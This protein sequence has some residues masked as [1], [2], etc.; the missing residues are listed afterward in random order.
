MALFKVGGRLRHRAAARGSAASAIASPQIVGS[1]DVLDDGRIV[2]WA[3]D[4]AVPERRVLLEAV[5]GDSR[6]RAIADRDRP[7]LRAAGQGDGCHGFEIRFDLRGAGCAPVHLREVV[8]GQALPGS[9]LRYDPVHLLADPVHRGR[10]ELLRAEAEHARLALDLDAPSVEDT[11]AQPGYATRARIETL[12]APAEPLHDPEGLITCYLAHRAEVARRPIS[13]GVPSERL[14]ALHWYL[15]TE[16]GPAGLPLS[17]GQLAY[18]NAPMPRFGLAHEVSVAAYNA[19]ADADL[20]GSGRS[21][22]GVLNSEGL[23]KALSWWCRE[24]VPGLTPDGALITPALARLMTRG[25]A[26]STSYPL[27]D[28]LR[29]ILSRDPRLEPVSGGSMLE[30]ALVVCILMLRC[31]R[32]PFLARFLP[33]FAVADL[34]VPTEAGKGSRF[35]ALLTLSLG[36]GEAS[37]ALSLRLAESLAARCLAFP[38]G[39]APAST[40]LAAAPSLAH[41]PRIRS[42]LASGIAVIG[43]A[44]AV[45]G[46]GQATRQSIAALAA[47]GRPPEVLDFMGNSPSPV[48][49]TDRAPAP[50]LRMPRT[51]NLLHINADT[52][53]QAFASIDSR[54]FGRSYNIGYV[55]WELD[56]VPRSHRLGLDLVDEVWVASEFNR[57]IYAE[58]CSVPVHNVGLAVEALPET[59]SGSRAKYGIPE[60]FVFLATFDAFS[61][62][63][64]KNPLGLIRA[65][66]AAFPPGSPEPVHLV[67]K[68]QNLSYTGDPHQVSLWQ[69]IDALVADDPRIRIIART[70]PYADVLG[71]KRACDVYVSL[72][73]SEGLGF[74]MIE[75]MQLGR[76]VIATAYSGNLEFCTPETAFLVDYS[77]VPVRPEEYVVVEPGSRWAE[78]SIPAAAAAMRAVYEAPGQAQA[79]A[80]A[81]SQHVREAFNPAAIGRRY[82]ARLA[83]IEAMLGTSASTSR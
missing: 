80:A 38:T 76:P 23:R 8:S 14:A 53:P 37:E 52:L 67:L 65:F 35:E 77:L 42:G 13:S 40:G 62:I 29:E 50:V 31:A 6:A 81:A 2:G 24:R 59:I 61:F 74:G 27:N 34:F 4:L 49:F 45:S 17:R 11:G 57:A 21:D 26:S 71:L 66:Q 55:F 83:A 33:A 64:R 46:L 60:G 22:P 78:P 56:A 58:A 39:R 5:C 75:A 28:F 36:D 43:P 9:P 44:R 72:H 18:L 20:D 1:V 63:A 68:T 32:T 3:R 41:D 69:M 79:R 25:E 7:D 19:I 47:V 70:L 82:E 12:L 48:G 30:R 10:R 16:A 54:V 15:A 51:I 73:R